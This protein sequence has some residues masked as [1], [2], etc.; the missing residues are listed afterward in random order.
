[1]L[2]IHLFSL[3]K[4]LTWRYF[5]SPIYPYNIHWKLCDRVVPRLSP[6]RSS[7]TTCTMTRRCCSSA[8]SSPDG[9]AGEQNEG[10]EP[11]IRAVGINW[12]LLDHLFTS[13]SHS[14]SSPH[15]TYQSSAGVHPPSTT[16][17]SFSHHIIHQL[18]H[19]SSR[20]WINKKNNLES[21]FLSMKFNEKC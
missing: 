20:Q 15:A 11:D 6:T 4:L 3:K 7:S 19:L 17:P 21:I 16:H 12:L 2:Q 14:A 18:D 13:I 5:T 8:I 9:Q 1:M 10:I